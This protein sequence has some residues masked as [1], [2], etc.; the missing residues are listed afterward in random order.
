MRTNLF[1]RRE[2]GTVVLLILVF[3]L[4]A[5]KEPRF[6]EG[7]SLNGIALWIPIIAVVGL[8]QMMV[9]VTRGI[10]VS[11]GSMTG[12]AA[13]VVGMTFRDN[14]NLPLPLGV[15]LGVATGLILGCVN[16]GLIAY[17]GVPP[18][19]ATLGSLSAYRGLVFIVSGGKQ[20]DSNNIPDALTQWSLD[21]PIKFGS[22]VIPWLF[23]MVLVIACLVAWFLTRTRAGR[24]IFA[25][26]SNPDAARL[27]GV[28]V[29]RTL[30]LVYALTGS[31]AGL[32]GVFYASRFGFVNP[33]SA[34]QGL[35]LIVIA[36]VVIGGTKVT[37]GT[38]SA[39]GVVLGSLLL[40]T[41]STA[42]A[43]L[44]IAA[45]WQ[46]LVYG[47]VILVAVLIDTAIK[48]SVGTDAA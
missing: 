24:D 31:L 32:A 38:G 35:E 11:V 12:L 25:L 7:S 33:G 23:A 42:L 13:M 28:P 4:V 46:Q 37:G 36:A 17:A 20:V 40:A 29:K 10:D 16:G 27:R 14:P 19:I 45:T 8:G 44:G 48:R 2:F 5:M 21:G 15:L 1:V 47:T 39:L 9:I 18:I 26:G 3:G 30:F 43:V 34:G 6:L 22:I 41:I